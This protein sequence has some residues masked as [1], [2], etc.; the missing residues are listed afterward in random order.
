[1]DSVI[2]E[3]KGRIDI[4]DL[5]AETVKLKR[6][7]HSF[8]GLCPFHSNT[9]SPAFVVWA[10]TGTWKCFG[11]CNTGGDVFSFVMKRDGI[12]F[13]EA[14]ERLAQR[15]G[16]ELR[17]VSPE[18]R[19]RIQSERKRQDAIEGL[20][21]RAA[22]CFLRQ[23]W[24]KGERAAKGLALA[25]SR[26]LSDEQLNAARWGWAGSDC[27]LFEAIK[28]ADANLLPIAREIG[29]VRADGRDFTANAEGDKVSP[30]GW[31][32]YPHTR[33]GRCVYLSAR[34]VS[35]VEGGDK[36]RNLPG[37]RQVYRADSN[38]GEVLP[39]DKLVLVEGPADA[40]SC[41]AWGVAAWAMCGA[42][43]GEDENGKPTLE[44]LRKRAEHS[45]LYAAMSND[46]AGKHFAD[47][48]SELVSPLMRV[49]LWPR[50][51]G[52]KKSDANDWLKRGATAEQAAQLLDESSTYL[53][54]QIERTARMR[55]VKARAE[56]IEHLADLVAR[57]DETER[58][59]FIGVIGERKGLDISRREFE[60][61]V[62][63]RLPRPDEIGPQYQVIRGRVCHMTF[64]RLGERAPRPLFQGSIQIVGDVVEDDGE[65]QVRRFEIAGALPDGKELPH[66][67]VDADEFAQ[68]NWLLSKWGTQ[69]IMTAGNS[70]KE[71][72]RAAILTLSKDVRTRYDYSHLGWREMDSRKIYLSAAGAVGLE[73]VRVQVGHDMSFYRMPSKPQNVTE[74]VKASLRFLNV[75]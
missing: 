17:Q 41:R 63:E 3:I 52:A 57:L 45:T 4:V 40:E 49:V 42:P 15:T 21:T 20:L 43:V 74:A 19:E 62:A 50:P 5:V 18:E 44:A 47:K 29:L 37:P 68:M 71:H 34:A 23:L 22:E 61:M 72:L 54:C 64:D 33:G 55:D 53:D 10:E 1:M 70:V 11:A 73:N 39:A 59:I 48:I 14:L 58:S 75:G 30:D 35:Q 38:I 60:R 7:G 28:R 26:A 6:S 13:R 36:S 31:L 56:G 2:E 46:E 9:K 67:E 24:D 27:A 69:A 25:R 66:I 12:E 51:E 65:D 16:V 32:I 8:T